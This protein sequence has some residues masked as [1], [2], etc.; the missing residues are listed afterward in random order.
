[1][2]LRCY[3][4]MSIK[5][6]TVDEQL[7][8]VSHTS[9]MTAAPLGCFRST[10]I[11]WNQTIHQHR[12]IIITDTLKLCLLT[13]RNKQEVWSSSLSIT[14]CLEWLNDLVPFRQPLVTLHLYNKWSCR[15]F[16]FD[17]QIHVNTVR[18]CS[19]TFC[20]E[21][22]YIHVVSFKYLWETLSY[23]VTDIWQSAAKIPHKI[24]PGRQTDIKHGL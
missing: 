3:I 4:W 5:Y 24:N 1:M 15:D 22:I 2:T 13:G 21:C 6:Q 23:K 10:E 19:V 8:W 17:C 20:R 7:L 11:L 9:W 12:L 18:N 16:Y 14:S